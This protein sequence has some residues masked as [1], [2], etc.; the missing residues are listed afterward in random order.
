MD[1][2]LIVSQ[3]DQ[4]TAFDLY[5]LH[6]AVGRLMDDPRRLD[7]IK[8][9]LHPGMEVSYFDA[10]KNRLFPARILEI[11]RTRAVVQP[12]P[13]GERWAVPMFA[14]NLQ[15]AHTDI[16]PGKTGLDRLLLKIG[17]AVG[18]PDKDGNDRFGQVIK[19]NPK[20]AKIDTGQGVWAVPYSMLFPVV[21][22]ERAPDQPATPQIE[23]LRGDADNST[24]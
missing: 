13:T 4:A 18:F 20:R 17:D 19:L 14:I 8:R 23:A 16:A 10:R 24:G 6:A 12:V 1:F 5:R 11:R 9:S 3:L 2:D 7:A 22:G 15:G 21:D